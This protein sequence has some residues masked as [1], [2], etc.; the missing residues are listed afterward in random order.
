MINVTVVIRNPLA[1]LRSVWA[2]GATV[3][4]VCR[5]LNSRPSAKSCQQ[6]GAFFIVV[7]PL[8]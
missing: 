5:L 2:D 6:S 3:E 7:E 1:A 4:I 8:R